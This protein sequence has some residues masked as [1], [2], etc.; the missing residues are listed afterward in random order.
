MFLLIMS[1]CLIVFV[2]DI[3]GLSF[4]AVAGFSFLLEILI[5]QVSR[6]KS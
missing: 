5:R 2:F 3:K 6:Y 1:C 4:E